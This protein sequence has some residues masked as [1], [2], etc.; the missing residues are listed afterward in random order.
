VRNWKSTI[1]IASVIA[2]AAL[3][4]AEAQAPKAA[5]PPAPTP[6]A[7][8]GADKPTGDA[9]AQ[10]AEVKPPEAKDEKDEKEKKHRPYSGKLAAGFNFTSGNSNTKSFNVAV[11]MKYD[12]QTK[13]VFKAEAFYLRNVEDSASTVDRT[14]AHLRDEY[15]L[16]P[17]WFAFGDGQFLK[18]RFKGIDSLV[19]TTAGAGV[20]LIKT[21][22][23]ELTADL[24]AG[25]VFEKDQ[26]QDR[27]SSGALRAGESYNWKISKSAGFTQNVFAIWKTSDFADAYY[28][29]DVALGAEVDEHF[30]LKVALIDEY[31][32][33]PPDP[34]IKR[35]DVAGIVQLEAKF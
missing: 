4:F 6:P 28:H 35:N 26:D 33:K 1:F 30:E 18:D 23:R 31:K 17:R 2:L 14:T 7:A 10:E 22:E 13:N 29:F 32:R 24:G 15:S 21:P 16:G 27:T 34:T 12:P 19:S 3:D 8:G 9:M 5:A 20:R 11:A 25:A